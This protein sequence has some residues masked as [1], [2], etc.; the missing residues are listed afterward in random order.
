VAVTLSKEGKVGVV[1]FNR[2]PANSYDHDFMKELDQAIYEARFDPAVKVMVLA[3]ELPRFF[4]AGADVKALAAGDDH[5]RA[6]F[7]LHAHE[8]LAKLER[9]P[10]LVIAAIGGFCLGGGLEIALACDLRFMA[11]GDER[12]PRIGLPEITLGVIPGT[13]GTQRLPRLIGMSKAIDLMVTGEGVLADRALE[14]GMVDKVFDAE[15]LLARTMEYAEKL[16]SGPSLAVG[17]IKLAAQQ[18][19]AVPLEYGNLIE[20][21]VLRRIFETKDAA[22]GM[23]AFADKRQPTWT[24]K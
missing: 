11:R 13:G 5:Y 15:E 21:E 23:G 10:K 24:G 14:L 20:R 16:A 12:G 8:I 2:P 9:T 4:C 6:M 1:K 18:G 17:A 22:E 3:S 7:D 19:G